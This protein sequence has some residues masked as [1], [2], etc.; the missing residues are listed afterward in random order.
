[1]LVED[2][3]FRDRQQHGESC[4]IPDFGTKLVIT[5]NAKVLQSSIEEFEETKVKSIT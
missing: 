1:M 4:R 5:T 3:K 2:L